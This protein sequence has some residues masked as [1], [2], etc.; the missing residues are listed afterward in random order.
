MSK[1]AYV[2][3]NPRL[4]VSST[5]CA[6]WNLAGP[7]HTVFLEPVTP[8]WHLVLVAHFKS[9]FHLVAYTCLSSFVELASFSSFVELAS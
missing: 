3:P 9:L 4:G 5:N 8:M 2:N 1:V 6:T 7:A